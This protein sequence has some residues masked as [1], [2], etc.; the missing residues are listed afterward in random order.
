[1]NYYAVQAGNFYDDMVVA[2][3]K[4]HG[5]GQVLSSPVPADGKII[6]GATDGNVY[7]LS[8]AMPS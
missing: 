3:A 4:L 7:A 1:V 2:V 6:F 8:V 5:L